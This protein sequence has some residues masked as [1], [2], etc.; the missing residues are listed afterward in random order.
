MRHN[1][2]LLE[3]ICH[4][5]RLIS[6]PYTLYA[7]ITGIFMT[8]SLVS[9]IIISIVKD[10]NSTVSTHCG[11]TQFLPS[12]SAAVGNHYPQRTIFQSAVVLH[13]APRIFDAIL[14]FNRESRFAHRVLRPLSFPSASSRPVP[15]PPLWLSCVLHLFGRNLA[16]THMAFTLLSLATHLVELASLN[17][18]AFYTSNEHFETHKL[19]LFLFITSCI[20]A[21]LS[22]IAVQSIRL[23]YTNPNCTARDSTSYLP[24]LRSSSDGSSAAERERAQR[25]VQRAYRIESFAFGLKLVCLPVV[26]VSLAI[27]GYLYWRH[28]LYCEPYLYSLFALCEYIA[29]GANITFRWSSGLDLSPLRFHLTCPPALLGSAFLYTFSDARGTEPLPTDSHVVFATTR[30][31]GLFEMRT[32]C[33]LEV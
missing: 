30:R 16:Q 14:Q 27:G 22:M 24:L 32:K 29:I 4:R 20:V 18:V 26:V 5:I 12:F 31:I 25:A 33:P 7:S 3:L 1:S 10:F 23:H 9:C 13:S 11:N 19:G 6:I 17:V 2:P 15:S 21:M 28:N 8:L